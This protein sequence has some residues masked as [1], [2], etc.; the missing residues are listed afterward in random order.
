MRRS[1]KP[2]D[3]A[4]E[5][6][7]LAAAGDEAVLA[8]EGI[9]DS[10]LY[11]KFCDSK[12]RIVVGHSKSNV[13]RAV[14]ECWNN[15]HIDNVVGIVDADLDRIRGRRRTPPVFS[16]DQRD[17]ETMLLASPA[18]DDVLAEYADRNLL[19]DFT[20]EYGPVFE[21]VVSAC[22]PIGLMMYVS[23]K[24]K[25]SLNFRE[26]DFK[27]FIHP[28]SLMIDEERLLDE[29]VLCTAGRCID[30]RELGKIYRQ[31]ASKEHE[32]LDYARGH[33]AV[34]VLLIG[35]KFNFGSFNAK[36][37]RNG[38][39]A[40]ALRLAFSEQYFSMTGLYGRTLDWSN[41]YCF[42]LWSLKRE[43]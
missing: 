12:V 10:R 6:S 28:G 2:E 22:Y 26:L 31:E 37:L 1:L 11:G 18:L 41:E 3:I 34:E 43:L 13:R 9:T 38:E 15:R 42:D 8:V 32:P 17:L 20:E 36:N 21:A 14:D 35:L 7:M 40:G 30:R 16:T 23:E 33:D 5:I 39:L 19:D 25:L 24:Y 29:I 27:R 4:N